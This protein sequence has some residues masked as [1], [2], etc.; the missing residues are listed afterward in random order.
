M[1]GFESSNIGW[2]IDDFTNCVIA[3]GLFSIDLKLK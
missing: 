3:S 1:A 2:L